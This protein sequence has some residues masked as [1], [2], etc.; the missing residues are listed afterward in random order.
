MSTKRFSKVLNP[1]WWTSRPDEIPPESEWV[2]FDVDEYWEKIGKMDFESELIHALADN[3]FWQV[4]LGHMGLTVRQS[5][6]FKKHF[7]T[8][9]A[10]RGRQRAIHGTVAFNRI[11]E[12]NL[13]KA[14][15]AVWDCA[16]PNLETGETAS[17]FQDDDGREWDSARLGW[18]FVMLVIHGKHQAFKKIAGLLEK[19]SAPVATELE[20]PNPTNYVAA[21]RGFCAYVRDKKTLPTKL[22]F[23]RVAG[24]LK[25]PNADSNGTKAMR[26][27]GLTGLPD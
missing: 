15:R 6:K 27:L 13:V 24:L 25:R 11:S 1:H 14:A 3:E 4:T 17:L 22:A 2:T 5:K 18:E 19:S 26:A 21:W 12:A 23:K 7:F 9:K 16:I 20:M 10:A 8:P